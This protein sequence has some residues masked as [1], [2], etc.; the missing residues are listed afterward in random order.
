M[1]LRTAIRWLALAPPI[2]IET[3]RRWR[4]KSPDIV[5]EGIY[6]HYRDVPVKAEG[7][8]SAFWT[9]VARRAA[10][11]ALEA[12]RR[13]PPA[14]PAALPGD[15]ALLAFLASLILQRSA[16]LRVL[17]FGGAM[18]VA[19]AHLL[20]HLS[21]PFSIDYHVVDTRAICSGGRDL[22]RDDPRIHFHASLPDLRGPLDILY[23]NSALQYNE[24]YAGTLSALCRY[25]P[26][27]FLFARLS[28]GDVPTYAT[29]QKNMPGMTLAYWF[30]NIREIIEI[31]AANGYSLIF[32]S[33]M[34]QEAAQANFPPDHRLDYLC[35]LLFVPRSEGPRP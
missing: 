15:H 1:G 27:Y 9:E 8:D 14:S 12:A 28:A 18:G 19:Y 3:L 34:A 6:P 31:M 30:I 11:T 35:N 2:A 21:Q 10:V 23:L 33:A 7:H 17:D 5:W 4:R 16:A 29:L 26:R 22:F 32:R 24:D 13:A 20:S 25:E